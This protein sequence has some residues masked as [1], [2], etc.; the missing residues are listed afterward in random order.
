MT[1]SG[2]KTKRI[3]GSDETIR[4]HKTKRIGGS[5][6]TNREDEEGYIKLTL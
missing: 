3:D 1:L 6:E 5:D 4:I 2:H